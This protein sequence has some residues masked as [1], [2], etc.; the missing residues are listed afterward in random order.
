MRRLVLAM[1]VMLLLTGCKTTGFGI[2]LKFDSGSWHGLSKLAE[3][4][5]GVRDR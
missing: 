4:I 3:L 1:A 2:P 5:V